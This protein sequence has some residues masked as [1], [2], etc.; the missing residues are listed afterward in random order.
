MRN[1]VVFVLLAL[2]F[3]GPSRA[4]P[5]EA[6]NRRFQGADLFALQYATD[7]QIRPDGRDVAYVRVSFD[8]MTDRAR[9]SIWLIDVETGEQTPLVAGAGSHTSPRWS[10][11]GGRLA[12]VSTAEGGRPQLYRA[13]DAER[14]RPRSSPSWSSAPADSRGR[15]TGAWI[16]FTMF[17]PDEAAKL[18]EAPAKPEGAEWAPPLEVITDLTYRS[19]ARGLSQAGLPPRVRRRGRRR[20]AA[21]T[22]LR[23]L[24]RDRSAVLDARRQS[25]AR[26]PATG[27]M[28][29][30]ASPSTLRSTRSRWPAAPSGP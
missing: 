24:Q 10:P 28:T 9:Q 2:L 1:T 23:R 8:I 30:A 16:A 3:A 12:Y 27:W 11:D 29:G 5:L 25:R 22:H 14:R 20:R 26:R 15:P 21:A 19:D 6:P 7:P 18:G 17:T 4:A 13:L